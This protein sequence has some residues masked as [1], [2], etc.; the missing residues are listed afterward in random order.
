[1]VTWYIIQPDIHIVAYLL[2]A[3][4]VEPEKQLLPANGFETTFVSRQWPRTS[5]ARQQILN[6]QQWNGVF[7]AVRAD[8]L[9]RD[10]LE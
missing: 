1:V 5:I 2:K 8:K 7:C 4:T 6:K 9:N 10:G 3:R